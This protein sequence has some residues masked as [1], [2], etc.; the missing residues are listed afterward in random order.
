MM[1]LMDF[2][3]QI[4][5]SRRSLTRTGQERLEQLAYPKQNTDKQAEAESEK[6][7]AQDATV[8]MFCCPEASE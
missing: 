2:L 3:A 1:C 8:P 6:P 4:E 5:Q 7:V